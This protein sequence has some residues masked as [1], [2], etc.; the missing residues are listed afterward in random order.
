MSRENK[1]RIQLNGGWGQILAI[2]NNSKYIF[3]ASTGRLYLW[4]SA[5]SNPKLIIL[6]GFQ[7]GPV[8][9]SEFTQLL[10]AGVYKYDLNTNQLILP[11]FNLLSIVSS[12][13]G[14]DEDHLSIDL[15]IWNSIGTKLFFQVMESPL[16]L[17]EDKATTAPLK[18]WNGTIDESTDKLTYDIFEVDE[19]GCVQSC[20]PIGDKLAKVKTD[21]I[22][23]F[24]FTSGPVVQEHLEKA[25]SCFELSID[26]RHSKIACSLIG[27][28]IL[29]F[30]FSLNLEKKFKISDSEPRPRITFHAINGNLYVGS[31]NVITAFNLK[32]IDKKVEV[33]HT[34][35]QVKSLICSPDGKQLVVASGINGEVIEAIKL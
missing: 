6:P 15:A 9:Q 35:L 1:S 24:D 34:K 18:V 7:K 22:E 30:D 21:R 12:E 28:E 5:I 3:A 29:L 16:K 17:I 27:A 32:Q 8:Y 13:V 14:L 11:K 26:F 4:E 19:T 20:Q 23:I 31:G 25:F 33:I 10:H 2:S